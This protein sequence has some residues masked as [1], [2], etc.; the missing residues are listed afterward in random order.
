MSK[1]KND[2]IFNEWIFKN[3]NFIVDLTSTN[4]LITLINELILNNQKANSVCFNRNL[5]GNAY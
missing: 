3:D 5:N 1:L 4:W 2:D